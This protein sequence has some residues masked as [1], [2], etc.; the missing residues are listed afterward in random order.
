L[1]VIDFEGVDYV[2]SA[3]LAAIRNAV[4]LASARRGQL[5]VASLCEPLRITF[6]LAGLLVDLQVEST[7]ADA[8]ARVKS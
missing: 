5:A 8:I 3:G 2:S 7:R 4:D 6:D 1:T